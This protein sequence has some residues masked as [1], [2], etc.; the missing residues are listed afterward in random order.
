MELHERE[1]PNNS[2]Y[3]A[4]LNLLNICVGGLDRHL[5]DLGNENFRIFIGVITASKVVI[6][7]KA[8]D[9]VGDESGQSYTCCE[10]IPEIT[11]FYFV[12]LKQLRL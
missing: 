6:C 5:K 3:F 12:M 7:G 2:L 11:I 8:R 10:Y 1:E 9:V 4:K